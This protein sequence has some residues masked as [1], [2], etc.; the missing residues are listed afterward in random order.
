MS[1][2]DKTHQVPF[3]ISMS[4]ISGHLGRDEANFLR[5]APIRLGAGN[6]LE[7]G[8]FH[9]RSTLCIAEGVRDSGFDSHLTSIDA[10]DLTDRI[11]RDSD[12]DK[13]GKLANKSYAAEGRFEE[14]KEVI[15]ERGFSEY[16]TVVRSFS[17]DAVQN[18]QNTKF[19]F[20]FIDA[21]HSYEGCKS[22]F[23]AWS[24]LVVPGGEIAF[25]DSNYEAVQRVIDESGWEVVAAVDQLKVIR[26]EVSNGT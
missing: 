5:D 4:G 22:D 21:D 11:R 9:G 1:S 14:V 2:W 18:Y 12:A 17:I 20:V 23:E 19:N 15:E 10:F 7:I 24:P 6:Y 25:H 13:D 3:P 26:K 16:V 8:V